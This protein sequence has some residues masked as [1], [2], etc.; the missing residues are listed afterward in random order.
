MKSKYLAT[1]AGKQ[2][3]ADNLL[4]LVVH[5]KETCYGEECTIKLSLMAVIYRDLVGRELDDL[6]MKIFM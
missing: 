5:H 1:P 4:K 2:Q 6:E 3:L